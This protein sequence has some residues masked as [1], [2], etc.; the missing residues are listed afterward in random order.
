MAFL[1][2]ISTRAFVSLNEQ[3][4]HLTGVVVDM[5][6]ALFTLDDVL[7]RGPMVNIC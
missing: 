5:T 4:G 1:V 6:G 3:F 7:T 2:V